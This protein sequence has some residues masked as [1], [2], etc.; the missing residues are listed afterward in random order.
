MTKRWTVIFALVLVMALVVS[1]CA[2]ERSSLLTATG[3]I[4]AEE[5]PVLAEV[6]GTLK[7][8]KVSEGDTVKAGQEVARLQSDILQ[9]QLSQANAGFDAARATLDE[10]K[11]GSRIQEIAAAEQEAARLK[12][13]AKG[14]AEDLALQEGTLARYEQLYASGAV[15][16]HELNVQK[17][18]TEKARAQNDAAQAAY[19]ASMARLDMLREGARKEALDRAAAQVKGSQAGVDLAKSYLEKT[20]LK[21]PVGGMVIGTNFEP[22]EVVRQGAEVITLLNMQKLWLGTYV[23]ENRLG[24]VQVGQRVELTVDSFPDKVFAGRVTFISP[25]AEFTPRNVQTKEDRVRLVFKVKI[26]LEN[27]QGLLKPGMPADVTFIKE[28]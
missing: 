10:V 28:K 24:E 13:L 6:S 7:E 1:G 14:A 20:I 11:A 2:N 8:L 4:E 21:A 16:E 5:I 23:P 3:T 27:G 17:A 19:K 15:T 22:G 18:L 12:A 26:F 25:R 9:T